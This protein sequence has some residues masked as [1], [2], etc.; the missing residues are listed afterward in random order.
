MTYS[1]P[2]REMQFLLDHV[3]GMSDL[4]ALDRYSEATPDLV[5]AILGEAG[6]FTAEVLAPLRRT[7]DLQGSKLV[8][9][10]VETPA[11]F[12][13]AYAQYVDGGWNALSAD[14]EYGGQGMP[15]ILSCAFMEMITSANMAFGLCPMLGQGAVEALLA[16]AVPDLQDRYLPNLVSG[17][18][19]GTMNLTEPQAGSDVG[20]LRT[21]ADRQADGSYLIQGQKI[22]ITWG[23]HDV[24]ENVLHLVLA[25]LPDAPQGTKGIS[26]FLVPK[27]M[28]NDDG[29]LGARND[30]RVVSLEHKLGIHA[31]PTCVMAFGDNGGCVGYLIGEENKGMSCMFTM[32]NHARLN[33]G[34]QG[35]GCA[36]L[37]Y[38]QAYAYARDRVQG[39]PMGTEPADRAPIFEHADVRRMLLTMKAS[40]EAARA[41][42]FL[43]ANAMDLAHNATDKEDRWWNQGLADLLTPLSKGY[44]TDIGVENA[45]LAVQVHGGMGF[46][47]ETGVAQ[48]LRDARITPI[49]E[50]TN[51]IQALDLVG[52]KLA[53]DGGEHWQALFRRIE[54]FLNSLPTDG[55]L[56]AIRTDLGDALVALRQATAWIM[57]ERAQN[58]RAVAAGATPYLRLFSMTVGGYLLAVGAKA[59]FAELKTPD[60]DREFLQSRVVLARFFA[61]QLLP[62]ASALMGPITRGD[63]LL[64]ALSP[65]QLAV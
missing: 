36:E 48:T 1:A 14:P 59:A 12:K 3:V 29:S 55:D 50:G 34:L 25:R 6:K 31:S 39:V 33:V 51:G 32:M 11:G 21:K 65:D 37:A 53:Q 7:G 13:E 35:I 22:F 15:F 57:A 23:D 2:L 28:I 27:F 16:H 42:A 26:L 30:L 40:T 17:K 62:P 41:I 63:G 49:Y 20:A 60:A 18:W 64:F 19:T 45:S 58:M 44:G 24:A 9:G 61:E 52:R 47:E 46:I 54:G 38:Q 8:N 5:A 43:N 56:G 4:T 10:T